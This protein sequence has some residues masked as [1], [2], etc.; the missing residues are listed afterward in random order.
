M[1]C[2]GL[3]HKDLAWLYFRLEL[4]KCLYHSRDDSSPN[5]FELV[6]A[7]P[8]P[9]EHGGI[10][11]GSV[12]FEQVI[13][14]RLWGS[15]CTN[16]AHPYRVTKWTWQCCACIAKRRQQVVIMRSQLNFQKGWPISPTDC[17][18]ERVLG[19]NI[20]FHTDRLKC[21]HRF[22]LQVISVLTFLIDL[23]SISFFYLFVFN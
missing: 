10:I 20:S 6:S 12:P 4:F 11:P 14:L 1:F 19:G 16:C 7:F 2:P 8:W 13:V 3:E 9:R 23:I 21:H 5:P 18:F 15:L 22:V 17:D